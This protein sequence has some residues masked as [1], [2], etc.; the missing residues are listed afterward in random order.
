M[1]SDEVRNE[2]PAGVTFA[3]TFS[4][5]SEPREVR[6]RYELAPD[7]T[8]ATAIAECTGTSTVSCS[9]TL[10]SGRGIF[11]IPGAEITYHWEVED[12]SGERTSTEEK[13]YTHEDTRFDFRTLAEGNVTVYYHAGTESQA[14][15]VLEAAVE[16]IQRVGALEQ[17]EV[18]FP[19]K[20]F[21]YRTA[22]EMQPAIAPNGGGPGVQILG[23]VVYSDTA[24]VSVDTGALDIVRHEIAHI[25]TGQATKGPFGI[26]G[27]MNEGISVFSQ[28]QP[29]PGHRQALD[30]AV[31]ADRALTMN[32]L[33]SSATGAT[34]DTVGLYYGQSGDMIRY[35][36]ETYG[37][38]KFA[39]LLRTFKEGATLDDGFDQVYGFDALGFEN[40]WRVSTGLEPR[41]PA[42]EPTTGATEQARPAPTSEPG[43]PSGSASS[44][45]DGMGAVTI[46]II[47]VLSALVLAS[48]AGAA[49]AVRSRLP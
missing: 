40:E 19:V 22:S 46:A 4:S 32:Q 12:A 44:D 13:L 27:W 34:G 25:V 5:P 20:V 2:F 36:V 14:P 16:A 30:T 24:M 33:N 29:L 17:T 21:V 45:D 3:L 31:R 26:P 41:A 9:Y 47:A 15:T 48:A 18:P 10:T 43:R 11:I 42:P 35:L 38:E 28:S 39:E 8:G 23:E 1:I 6:V 37:E 7:G 49:V